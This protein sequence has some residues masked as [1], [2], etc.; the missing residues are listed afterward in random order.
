M[1]KMDDT[2]F[3]IDT[4]LNSSH[5]T[6]A[7]VDSGC[8]CYS[9]FDAA[10]VRQMKLPRIPIE[11]RSLTLAKKDKNSQTIRHITYADVDIDGHKERIFGYVISHLAYPVILGDPWM[12]HNDAVYCA[13]PRTLRIGS[14]KHGIVVHESGW[15]DRL[16][17]KDAHVV[18]GS[19]MVALVG[20]ARRD[21]RKA[22]LRA[23]R[24]GLPPPRQEDFTQ[25]FAISMADIDKALAKLEK[26]DPMKDIVKI[27][28]KLPAELNDLKDNFLDDEANSV[29]PHRPGKDHAINLVKDEQ[30]RE[31]A[32]PW[33]P[34][35]QMSR[36][37]LLV[38]R[39][40]LTDLLD[41]G[42]IRASSSPAASPVLFTR[43]PGGGL[44]LCVD[45][46]ALNALTRQDRYPL[47]LIRETLR[48]MAK[49]RWLTK[50]DVRWAF[51]RLRIREGDEW[52]TAFRTRFGLF[53]WLV[54]PF[55]LSGAPA[56][57]QRYINGTLAEFLDRFVS[58][59]M[60][61]VMIYSDGSYKDHM[62]KVRQVVE[63]L[64]KAGLKLDIDKCEFAVKEVKYLGF[65]ISAGE[66]VK[67]DPEKVDAIRSWEAP[68]TVKAVRSFLGFANFYRDFIEDFSELAA[69]L[70][71][72]TRKEE[73]WRWKKAEQAAFEELKQRFITAPIL[74]HF[75]PEKPTILEADCSGYSL[76]ACLSQVDRN[77]LLR[78]VAYFSQKLSPAQSNYEIHDKEM[79]AIV[80]AMEEWRSE[81]V[82]TREPFVVLTDHKNLRYF[83]SSR[84]LSERQIRWSLLLS[85]FRFKLEFRA[86]KKAQRPDALSRRSQDMPQG[87][88]DERLK[89]RIAQLIKDE[90][91][92]PKYQK[93]LQAAFVQAQLISAVQIAPMD[94]EEAAKRVPLGREVF[95]E[96]ELQLM[97]DRGVQEDDTFQQLYESLW[98]EE[99]SF[100][101]SCAE[102]KISIGECD[103]DGR[104][105]LR[106]RKR[107]LIPRWE[108]LQ[109]SLI[110]KTHDSHIT[111]H[112][113]RDTTF[114]ML[115]RGFHWPGMSQMVRRFCRNCD[116]CGRSHVWRERRKGLLLPLPIPNR[117]HSELSI[118][119]MTDLP[120]ENEGDP[121][122]LMVIT[123]RLLKSVT[124]EAMDTMEAEAC[125]ERF[126]QCHYRFHGFPR[127]ITSDRG[128]NWVGKF[129]TKLCELVGIEQRL[130]TAFHPETDGATER[131]NQE[132]QAYLRAFVTYAQ[133]DWHNFLPTAMLAI[134][135]RDTSLGVS[136]FFL[137]HG[138][139]VEPIQ[140]VA[141]EEKPSPPTR[142]AE[143]FV[144]RLKE[145][146]EF[147]QAA[148]AS[149]QQRME[150]QANQ[151]RKEAPTLKIGDLVWLNL[152]NVQTP[153][154]SKKLS[155]VNAK[156]R[157]TKVVSPHVVELD[158]P[159]G[160]FP[161][162][163]VDLLKKAGEDP[164]PSQRQ[165]DSQPPPLIPETENTEAEYKV[166]RILQAVN[167][168]RGRGFRR[169]VLVKWVGYKNPT[170]EPRSYV[171]DTAAL[172]EFEAKYGKGDG[173]G[174]TSTGSAIGR[175]QKAGESTPRRGRG[176]PKEAALQSFHVH[177]YDWLLRSGT[178]LPRW[179]RRIMSQ[180]EAL[181]RH[182]LCQTP[183]Y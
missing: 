3:L 34:L 133:Y 116:V 80:K 81:L 157:V 144:E 15:M 69:P 44:R 152:K 126:L 35:Y 70:V 158:V 179:G 135:N 28:R 59:Y 174:E 166:E 24:K 103:L 67:V 96:P 168:P 165:D 119:F 87:Q 151:G 162:F 39:K 176:R 136:P 52:K 5:F 153:Q 10:L 94:L 141:R 66:G 175:K 19:V 164:L 51:H 30:G 138:Y 109:T 68:T 143:D 118:D 26:K 180:A 77:G 14:R 139:H 13:G 98:K 41:K 131:M 128:T 99:R 145:A 60:D 72:L 21:F 37:E 61:D 83:M 163:H 54:T 169:E 65:I 110:Q 62:A 16:K 101:P 115:R 108:P 74:A 57:F 172:D 17:P 178:I 63:R 76:G 150:D 75:D 8:L 91:L 88:D 82:S 86:G 156:Y 4:Q 73:P 140:Q 9:A 130:S 32:A 18:S 36:E 27:D 124:L 85:Q 58:A 43:K 125:A 25:V 181:Y 42:W 134:N 160:I 97:W 23:E 20:R 102:W 53:E 93:D 171:E 159:T 71:R 7:F 120:A 106:F 38:L 111:G 6:Q 64:A 105:V 170:W 146:Q 12:R 177:S 45:Y 46:R 84:R 40:T 50:I 183:T 2:P 31:A 29:P 123:D 117:F 100:S 22:Q 89:N 161:K 56:T 148:M 155:W 122:Y 55:G 149:V 107:V 173:V 142:V 121:R 129:W 112:P 79:L 104:G 11:E 1:R 182:R 137:T 90:W 47:P 95:E 92:P 113:G 114:S 167:K 127:A 147:A 154:A 33:G 48:N 49:A 78:P 132:V